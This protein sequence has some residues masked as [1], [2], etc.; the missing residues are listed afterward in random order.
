MHAVLRFWLDRS[1][2]G[3]RVDTIWLLIKDAQFRNN[4]PNSGWHPGERSYRRL[5]PLHDADQPEVHEVIA[6]MRRVLDA[7]DQ[8]LLIGEIYLPIEQL[9][10][11][12]GQNLSGAHLPFNFQLLLAPWDAETVARIIREYQAALPPGAW[13]NW[14]LGNHDRSRVASRIGMQQARVAAILLL[15]V[16]G[17]PTIYCGEEIGMTDV[18]ILPERI[19]D[20][21]EKN[22]PGLGLGRDPERT[23]M[24]WD[25]SPNGGFTTGE[26]WLPL[27]PDHSVRNVATEMQDPTSMLS[28]YRKLIA[29][30][31]ERLAL[32]LGDIET[33]TAEHGVLRYERQF[34]SEALAIVLNFANEPRRSSVE[35]GRI[36]LSSTGDRGGEM[37]RVWSL[38][39]VSENCAS[40]P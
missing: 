35:N 15:T 12:Y 39:W 38:S 19:Q 28:L 31:R 13:P 14:V 24:P 23:P 32:S 17:T 36:L 4:P 37:T 7:Y 18:T 10:T 9:V 30:R 3:F 34:G 20:P 27:D 21:A 1:V 22:E 2:D 29:L 6:D 5:L 25:G 8:R 16:R 40:A 33:V 11:Y 26:P